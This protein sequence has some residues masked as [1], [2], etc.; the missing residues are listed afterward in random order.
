MS[1]FKV[2]KK[3]KGQKGIRITWADQ[4]LDLKKHP[5]KSRDVKPKKSE[6]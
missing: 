4:M 3:P 1:T 6:T 5:I 2:K